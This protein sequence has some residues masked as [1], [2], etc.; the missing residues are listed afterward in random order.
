MWLSNF[1]F[2]V[3]E[4]LKKYFLRLPLRKIYSFLL[5]FLKAAGAVT[6]EF[7][8]AADT[9]RNGFLKAT[10]NFL[11]TSAYNFQLSLQNPLI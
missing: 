8:K 3:L 1:H 9:H 5:N 4:I 10:G 2:I 6:E 11:K 7:L